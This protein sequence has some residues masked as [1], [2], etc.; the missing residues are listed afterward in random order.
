MAAGAWDHGKVFAFGCHTAIALVMEGMF[1]DGWDC[2]ELI[3]L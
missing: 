1:G 3:G 2:C